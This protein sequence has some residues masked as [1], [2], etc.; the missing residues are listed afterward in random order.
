MK[1][2]YERRL[3][4]S[5]EGGMKSWV[6]SF[7]DQP[8]SRLFVRVEDDFIQN[9]FN[10]TGMKQ[11][12]THFA[13]AYELIRQNTTFT[14]RGEVD[15]GTLQAEAEMLYGLIHTRFLLTKGGM[16]LMF[17]KFQE[18]DFQTCPRVNCRGA[19]CL[20]Y[21]PSEE[22]GKSKV[23]MYC[24]CCCDVYNVNDPVLSKID[25]GFFGPSW[26]HMF[27]Q[28]YAMVIP[29]EASKIYVPKIFGFR[30]MNNSDILDDYSEEKS[31]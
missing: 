16:Q 31:D 5:L 14:A 4:L 13:P 21:G 19:H 23:K 29:K 15:L 20:P 28:K 17:E 8:S 3:A 22:F 1:F 25:G 26:V 9:S 10:L 2:T 6:D 18:G 11:R 7:L 27:L 24:P 30:L 12:L